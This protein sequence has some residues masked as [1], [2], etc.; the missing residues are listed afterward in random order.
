[1]LH[2]FGKLG[3]GEGWLVGGAA[4]NVLFIGSTIPNRI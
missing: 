2:K 4:H 1:M 3:V